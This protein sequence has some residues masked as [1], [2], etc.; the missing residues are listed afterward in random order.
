MTHDTKRKK[1][2]GPTKHCIGRIVRIG[3]ASGYDVGKI[4]VSSVTYLLCF[5]QISS[6]LAERNS[7]KTGHVLGNKCDLKTHV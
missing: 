6:E 5:R 2:C 4:N 7:T 3:P 1:R